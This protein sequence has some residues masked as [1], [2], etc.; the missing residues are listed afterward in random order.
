MNEEPSSI[1]PLF[2][3]TYK[4]EGVILDQKYNYQGNIL[5][6]CNSSGD[7]IFYSANGEEQNR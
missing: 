7:I 6:V 5:A 3:Y 4:N 1:K 2:H